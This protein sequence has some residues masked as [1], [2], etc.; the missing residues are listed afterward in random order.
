MT[1]FTPDRKQTICREL[2]FEVAKGTSV[3]IFGP[4]GCGKSSLL[5]GI[6]GL[7]TAGEGSVTRP[8]DDQTMFI[9]QKPYL[10]LGSLRTQMLYPLTQDDLTLTTRSTLEGIL[11]QVQL[12]YVCGRSGGLDETRDWQDELSLGEQQARRGTSFFFWSI[13]CP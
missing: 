13:P 3:L 9:P 6:S 10:P 1:L 12:G 11:E 4:S 2:S 8:S 5:R 7:W